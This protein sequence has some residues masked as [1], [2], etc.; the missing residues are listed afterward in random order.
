MCCWL[1]PV[2]F[3]ARGVALP[4]L[5]LSVRLPFHL[6]DEHCCARPKKSSNDRSSLEDK[7]ATVVVGWLALFRSCLETSEMAKQPCF[8]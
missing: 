1:L 3:G 8:W 6:S 4:P 5:S 7:A 2:T